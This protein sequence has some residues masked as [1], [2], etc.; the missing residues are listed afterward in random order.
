MVFDEL[1]ETAVIGVP[2]EVFGKPVKAFVV[3]RA[4]DCNGLCKRMA[5]FR[6]H[7]NEG[8]TALASSDQMHVLP[9]WVSI[10][11]EI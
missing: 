7:I 10:P 4:R 6:E 8:G 2:D 3:P 5:I 1:V 9:K 11:H